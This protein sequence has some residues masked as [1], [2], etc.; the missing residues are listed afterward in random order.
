MYDVSDRFLHQLAAER[1]ESLLR[2][3][4]ASTRCPLRQALRAGLARL[5]LASCGVSGTAGLPLD[6]TQPTLASTEEPRCVRDPWTGPP[7]DVGG[8]L[9]HDAARPGRPAGVRGG[10]LTRREHQVVLL[11]DDTAAVAVGEQL[12]WGGQAGGD[13]RWGRRCRTQRRAPEQDVQ[14]RIVTSRPR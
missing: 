10:V 5:G 7:R 6:Q 8:R 11:V 14:A 3:G 13:V 1:R 12:P 2:S 4:R 9:I